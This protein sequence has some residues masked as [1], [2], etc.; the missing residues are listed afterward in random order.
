VGPAVLGAFGALALSG[1]ASGQ[2]ATVTPSSL[3]GFAPAPPGQRPHFTLT[4]TSGRPYDFFARTHGR[5][6]LLFWG[7]T[8]CKDTCPTTMHDIAQALAEVPASVREKV[9]VVFATSDPYRDTGPVIRA[10]LD[11]FDRSFVGLTGTP[12]ELAAA[13]QAAGVPPPQREPGPA[14]DYAVDHFAATAAFGRD[15]RLLVFYPEGTVTGD[16]AADL[17]VL[18]KA[19]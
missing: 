15:D 4:D 3:H 17:P 9:T 1:C 5:A 7:Y 18:V 12:R 11:R 19:S 16:Y 8:H 10:W 6:T 2:A 14:G 13:E